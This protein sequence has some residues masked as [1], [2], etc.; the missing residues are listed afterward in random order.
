MLLA[1]APFIVSALLYVPG[2]PPRL[3]IIA[4]ILAL[5]GALKARVTV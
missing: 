2:L 5:V 1:F 3:G 4:V